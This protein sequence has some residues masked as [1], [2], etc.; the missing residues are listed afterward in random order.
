VHFGLTDPATQHAYLRQYDSQLQTAVNSFVRQNLPP[1]FPASSYFQS[2][3][4]AGRFPL[5]TIS[6]DNFSQNFFPAQMDVRLSVIPEDEI[7]ALLE[8]S[9]TL[10]PIDLTLDVSA[11]ANLTVFALIPVSRDGFEA[12]VNRLPEVPVTGI[13]PQ[14]LGNRSPI[15]LLRF[16]RG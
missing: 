14:V 10:P 3:P 5:A 13:L 16:Y 4:P 2:L 9:M 6:T 11:F 8:D 15:D 12:L 7:P 1:N